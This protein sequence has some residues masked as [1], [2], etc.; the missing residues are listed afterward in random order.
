MD[1]PVF[2]FTKNRM[3]VRG[4]LVNNSVWNMICTKIII[5]VAHIPISNKPDPIA[6]PMECGK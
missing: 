4:A 1:V 5:S 3:V 2:T 6:K